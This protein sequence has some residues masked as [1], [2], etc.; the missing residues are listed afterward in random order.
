MPTVTAQVMK[1]LLMTLALEWICGYHIFSDDPGV[2]Q[3]GLGHKLLVNETVPLHTKLLI[4]CHLNDALWY[5]NGKLYTSKGKH[6]KSLKFDSIE[7]SDAGYY[8]CRSKFNEWSNLTLLVVGQ[9]DI[10]NLKKESLVDNQTITVKKVGDSYMDDP[11]K[12]YNKMEIDRLQP[13]LPFFTKPEQMI[14]QLFKPSGNMV[15]LRCAAD[16][17]PLPNI[18]WTKDYKNISR[19]MGVVKY[20]RWSIVLEDLVVKDSGTYTCNVCNSFGC[21]SFTTKLMVK[22]RFPTRPYIEE[23]SLTNITV[24]VNSTATFECRTISKLEPHI[25]WVKFHITDPMQPK[26]PENISILERNFDNPEI[27]TI[28]NVTHADEENFMILKHSS[29]M[30]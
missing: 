30:S 9:H 29:K 13:G 25:E 24:L 28:E 27:L 7:K 26:I 5:K 16:G 15:R 14:A 1:L 12:S 3:I 17:N 4:S 21:I 11:K 10:A 20:V 22:D 23:G 19:D 2:I 6:A 18:I 8:S